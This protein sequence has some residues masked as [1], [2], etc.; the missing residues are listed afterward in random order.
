MWTIITKI[1]VEAYSQNMCGHYQTMFGD[2]S[3]KYVW[4]H[5][6]FCVGTHIFLCGGTCIYV[7]TLV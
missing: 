7:E 2:L 1:S 4:R 5:I 3:P 6:F